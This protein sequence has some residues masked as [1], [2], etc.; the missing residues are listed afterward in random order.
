[1]ERHSNVGENKELMAAFDTSIDQFKPLI[2]TI[3]VFSTYINELRKDF[4]KESIKTYIDSVPTDKASGILK[5]RFNHSEMQIISYIE[6]NDDNTATYQ[7]LVQAMPFSQ[8]MLSR[9]VKRLST[10]GLIVKFHKSNDLKSILLRTTE[11][12]NS[13]ALIHN[14]LHKLEDKYYEN[15]L[16]SLP[17]EKVQHTLEVLE[18]ILNS[19]RFLSPEDRGKQNSLAIPSKV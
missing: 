15:L 14:E 5:K 18:I 9:Y 6:A 10:E 3:S 13:F 11:L 12:G 1:M 16:G 2:E 17:S 4:L 19:K 8:G 7:E